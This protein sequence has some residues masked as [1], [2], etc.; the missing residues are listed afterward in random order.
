MFL[1]VAHVIVG[2]DKG[3]AEAMLS[4]LVE[5]QRNSHSQFENIIISLTG[6]G[7][8]GKN[9]REQGIKVFCLNLNNPFYV[10]VVFFKLMILIR[11]IRPDIVQTWMVHSDL[12]GGVAAKVATNAHVIWGVR[13]TDY[14]V[15]SRSTR[16]VRWLCSMLSRFIPE[17]IVCAAQASLQ[18]SAQAGYDAGKLMVIP[19]GFEVAALRA[20]VG[21]GVAIRQQCGLSASHLVVGCLG[22]YNA[23]KDHA[24]F[25]RAAGLLAVQYRA[26]YFLM[27]GRDLT[28][29]NAELMALIQATGFADRFVLLGERSDPAA[30]LDA[31]NV[32]V[33]SSCTEGFPNVLGEA[34]AMGVPCVST[35]VGDAAYLLGDAGEV[36]PARDST[37]LAKA[38][39]CLLDLSDTERKALGAKGRARVENEFSIAE[40]ARRF[41]N[42][43]QELLGH[44]L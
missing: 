10:V 1:K 4:R 37:A 15:E 23:A 29:S 12:L 14:S 2:M 36:V 32:F 3:G 27:V 18:S 44:K 21:A 34:M 31:M 8:Y 41:G 16:A 42:L 7:Y 19:N 20:H 11:K 25:V 35:N 5:C 22:R 40:A 28:S 38:V 30:C 26:C 33:L 9:L 13:T 17:K 43:Y 24:N 39:A 6:V